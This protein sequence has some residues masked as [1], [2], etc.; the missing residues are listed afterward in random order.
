MA[1]TRGPDKAE[2]FPM[3]PTIASGRDR[4]GAVTLVAILT[5]LSLAPVAK[6]L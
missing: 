6:G 3:R 4:T 2:K 5:R 1:R